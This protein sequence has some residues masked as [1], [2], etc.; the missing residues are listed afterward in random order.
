MYTLKQIPSEAQIKKYIRRI[1]FGKNVFCPE[2]RSQKVICYESR[3]RCKACRIK[4]TLISHTWLKGMKLSWQSFWLSLW[5]WTTRVP[6]KQ[7]V[8][9]SKLSEEAVRRWYD[10]FRCH[11]PDNP[12][13][14][15]RVVQMDEAYGKG[16]A[17]LM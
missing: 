5:C 16:W 13:I 1:V 11:I 7:A 4:F 17:L 14:L 6:V 10:L 3:Y 8:S 2:C 9:L 15:E 12:L